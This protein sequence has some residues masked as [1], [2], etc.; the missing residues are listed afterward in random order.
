MQKKAKSFA[1]GLFLAL[2]GAV[3]LS[4]NA[5]HALGDYDDYEPFDGDGW[6][7]TA[8]GVMTIESNQG[9]ANCMK[10]GYKPGVRK[11][12]LGKDVTQFR[13]YQLT[14]DLPSP[15]FYD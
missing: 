1:L 11:L 4:L 6:S 5:A 2:V 14:D 8:A 9:W 12:V 7:I 10:D 13:I 3:C 15:D